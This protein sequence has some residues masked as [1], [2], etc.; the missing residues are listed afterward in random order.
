[1]LVGVGYT[2]DLTVVSH[3]SVWVEMKYILG[4]S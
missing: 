2:K 3:N 1:M 4:I